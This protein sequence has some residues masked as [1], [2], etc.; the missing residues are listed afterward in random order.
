MELAKLFKYNNSGKAQ[1]WEVFAD[2]DIV[3]KQYGLVGG[4]VTTKKYTAK[5]KNIGKANATTP[6]QQAIAEVKSLHA[7]KIKIDD[8]HEDI[9]KSG[10]QLRPMLAHDFL[11][12]PHMLKFPCYSQPKL[13]GVRG[14][15]YI[16]GDNKVE[17][18]SRKGELYIVPDGLA[19]QLYS[20]IHF[21]EQSTGLD[22]TLDGEY[23][24]HGT[25][26][27]SIVGGAKK[28]KPLT[29]ELEFHLFDCILS[30]G[31]ESIDRD[32]LTRYDILRTAQGLVKDIPKLLLVPISKCDDM[33][34]VDLMLD[35]FVL[36]GYEGIMLRQDAP[37]ELAKRS[38]TLIK[39]KRFM[40]DEFEIIGADKDKD[41]GV[42][43]VVKIPSKDGAEDL[44]C[45][46]RPMGTNEQ[47]IEWFNTCRHYFGK[48]LKVKFQGY[49]PYGNL[50][51]PTGVELD[52]TDC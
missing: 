26:L 19:V 32:F 47:R 35:T 14:L 2:G 8:Y 27:Q 13:D 6:E 42:I 22:V 51:F 34:Q 50:E 52:R 41:G 12:V 37:Y 45:N 4:K 36:Q 20:L 3:V 10:K 25:P 31:G 21:M 33:S 39:Y 48:L 23:Y 9:E 29:H 40:D 18:Q 17:V 43:W 5:A 30:S 11:K 1:F 16:N 24:L 49:N 46:V 28:M 38:Y 44:M 7:K 15:A